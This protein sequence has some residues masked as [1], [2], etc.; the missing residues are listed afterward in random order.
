MD[1][2]LIFRILAPAGEAYLP[3]MVAQGGAAT[4]QQQVQPLGTL[5]Q[6]DQHSRRLEP[7]QHQTVG[8]SGALQQEAG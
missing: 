4:G 8:G 5:H 6:G 7:R 1:Q 2:A 3:R